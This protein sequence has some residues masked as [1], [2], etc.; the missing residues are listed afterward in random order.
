MESL[1]KK[2][3]KKVGKEGEKGQRTECI[4]KIQ[5]EIW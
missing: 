5:I 3:L 1:K 4:N 2:I